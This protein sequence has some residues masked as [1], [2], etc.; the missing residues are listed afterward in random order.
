MRLL[1]EKFPLCSSISRRAEGHYIFNIEESNARD[2]SER[3]S[4]STR[5]SIVDIDVRMQSRRLWKAVVLP[6]LTNFTVNFN[7]KRLYSECHH[8]FCAGKAVNA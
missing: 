8:A 1:P 6:L 2:I 5:R 3:N 7:G 4:C